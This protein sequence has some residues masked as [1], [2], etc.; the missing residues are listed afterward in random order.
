M[1]EFKL[2]RQASD[3]DVAAFE[4]LIIPYEKRVYNIALGICKNEQDAY[5]ISQEV[6]IKVYKKLSSF[7]FNSTFST[8]LYRIVK[9]TA[10]DYLRK[11]SRIRDRQVGDGEL[12]ALPDDKNEPLESVLEHEDIAMLRHY[13]NI[14]GEPDRSILLFRELDGLSYEELAKVFDMKLGTVKSRIFRAKKKLKE[15]VLKDMEQR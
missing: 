12:A 10:L 6:F 14:L 1:D 7:G 8:W 11:E 4:K 5:D 15:L 2:I 9:N 3:G 13:L